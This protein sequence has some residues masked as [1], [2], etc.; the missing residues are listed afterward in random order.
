MREVRQCDGRRKQ[1]KRESDL[2]KRDEHELAHLSEEEIKTQELKYI[3]H[4]Q[5]RKI[6]KLW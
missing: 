2:D 4:E 3:K 1:S 5:T 6:W